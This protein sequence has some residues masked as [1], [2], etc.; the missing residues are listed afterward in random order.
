MKTTITSLFVPSPHR[1]SQ[2]GALFSYVSG[3]AKLPIG[4]HGSAH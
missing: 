4:G 3:H 1:R 2:G